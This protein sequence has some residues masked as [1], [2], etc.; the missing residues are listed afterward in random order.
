MKFSMRVTMEVDKNG[1]V[2]YEF[3]ELLGDSDEE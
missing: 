1:R 2:Y 3:P